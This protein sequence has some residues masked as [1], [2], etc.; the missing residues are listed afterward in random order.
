[1]AE[2][3]LE[4]I[5]STPVSQ[6][7]NTLNNSESS[8]IFEFDVYGYRSNIGLYLHNV[9]GGDADLNLYY[10]SNNNGFLDSNDELVISSTNGGNSSETI[11]Y[12]APT[13]QGTYFAEVF[14]YSLNSGSSEISYDLDLSFIYSNEERGLGLI[15]ETPVSLNRYSVSEASPTDVFEFSVDGTQNLNLSLHNI[16]SGDD[17]DLYLYEDTN[18]NG[19]F[20]NDDVQIQYSWNSGNSDD[21]ISLQADSGTYFAQVRRYEYDSQGSVYYD[22]DISTT[23]NASNLLGT[24][25]ELGNID[26]DLV[27]QGNVGDL[28]TTVTYEFSLGANEGV[29]LLLEG[30]SDDADIRVVRDNN[31]NGIVDSD[32]VLGISQNWNNANEVISGIEQAGNYFIQVYQYTGNTSYNLNVEHYSL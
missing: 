27:L 6:N 7:E 16:S 18:N 23:D 13:T 30:L 4:R 14:L 29:N 12:A 11:D 1:M 28:K 22:L 17:A 19:I 5:Q 31:N 20:D 26:D 21:S 32:E 24:D 15:D 8:D 10:D 3:D 9:N 2:F 25:V